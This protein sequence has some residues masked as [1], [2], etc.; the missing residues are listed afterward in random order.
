MLANAEVGTS[1]GTIEGTY[2]TPSTQPDDSEDLTG[3]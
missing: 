3:T 1:D 2:P